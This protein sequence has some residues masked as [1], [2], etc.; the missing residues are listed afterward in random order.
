VT[1]AFDSGTINPGVT[2]SYTFNQ[3]GSFEYGCSIHPS[4]PHGTVIVIPTATPTPAVTATP[5]STATATSTPTSTPPTSGIKGDVSGDGQVTV[6][7][8]LFVAQ[9]TVGIRT[10][11]TQQLVAADVNGDDQVTVVDALFISQYTVGLRQ[12]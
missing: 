8:A 1:G 7:D 12:L 5:T 11:T 4:I 2:Y 3:A 10:L 6:V 9:Y